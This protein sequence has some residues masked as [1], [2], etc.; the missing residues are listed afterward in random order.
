MHPDQISLLNSLKGAASC[1]LWALVFSGKPMRRTDLV[2]ATGYQRN[3]VTRGLQALEALHLVERVARYQGWRLTTRLG[4]LD[5][6]GLFEDES[7]DEDESFDEDE[8]YDEDIAQEDEF[9]EDEGEFDQTD[10]PARPTH[11]F[12]RA[13]ISPSLSRLAGCEAKISPSRV[14]PAHRKAGYSP[15]PPEDTGCEAKISPSQAGGAGLEVKKSPSPVNT[16]I[17]VIEIQTQDLKDI[18]QAERTS[19]TITTE[20]AEAGPSNPTTGLGLADGLDPRVLK[21]F[22][23]AGLVLN[24]RTRALAL[25]PHIT[26]HYVRAHFA[27]LKAD[28]KASHTGLLITRLEARIPAPETYPNGHLKTC[29]CDVCSYRYRYLTP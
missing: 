16:V 26:A 29:T 2:I 20:P 19:I 12:G 21:A 3:T 27:Q 6:P 22:R 15:S 14:E 8:S 11:P 1:I 4:Q 10:G 5:L 13:E 24:P 28:G 25:M 9:A 7:S 23:S 17:D 18:N